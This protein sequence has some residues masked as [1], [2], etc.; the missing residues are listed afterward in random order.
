MRS[1]FRFVFAF[2][3]LAG[4]WSAT[5]FAVVCTVPSSPH[6]T[7]Q[8]AGDDLAC[9]EVVLAA[10]TF[11]ES[12]LVERD[13]EIRGVSSATTLIEGRMVITGA[14]SAVVIEDLTID[15]SAPSVAGCFRE[16]LVSE[17][18]A[19]IQA[20]GVVVLN[21]DGDG[22]LVF[23]DGFESGGTGAWSSTTGDF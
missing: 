9:S 5:A 14:S 8:A 19:G 6:Q 11:E 18:G 23:G 13:I 4:I 3:F 20:S 17:G 2:V 7:I 22:C 21:G 12:V 16:A 1:T 10:Q 15:G